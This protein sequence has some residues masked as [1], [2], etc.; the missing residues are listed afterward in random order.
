MTRRFAAVLAL[1]FALACTSVAEPTVPEG[2]VNARWADLG[3][4][5]QGSPARSLSIFERS[6]IEARVPDSDGDL[7]NASRSM[8]GGFGGFFY[9]AGEPSMYLVEPKDHAELTRRLLDR[10]IIAEAPTRLYRARWT[11]VQLY[12]WRLYIGQQIH[13]ELIGYLTIDINEHA[14]RI[15]LGVPSDRRW[16]A[17]RRLRELRVPCYLVALYDTDPIFTQP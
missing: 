9:L 17:E 3:Y 10:E 12:D 5:W 11:W 1:P 14:N 2:E 6:R 4:C 13:H 15:D 8:P 7:A 16:L